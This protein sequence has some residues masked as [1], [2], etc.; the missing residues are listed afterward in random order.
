M[1][2]RRTFFFGIA[3][4]ASYLFTQATVSS[5]VAPAVKSGAKSSEVVELHKAKGLLEKADHDY[6]G[7]RV[8][9]IRDIDEAIHTLHH[10]GKGG[11]REEKREEKPGEK[12]EEKP[13][14]K[15]E[16]GGKEP[17]KKSDHE[18]REAMKILEEV[19]KQL[20]ANHAKGGGEHHA[21]AAKDVKHA[22]EQ[23]ADALKV[24]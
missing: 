18:L 2:F 12:K 17:Q 7:H 9:A 19:E 23:L 16:G 5:A 13:G 15:K 10:A 3:L 1:L 4:C 21:K 22:I 14:E 24:R 6:D 8:K 20:H 11:K